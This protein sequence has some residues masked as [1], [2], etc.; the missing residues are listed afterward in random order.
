M[1]MRYGSQHA[2]QKVNLVAVRQLV[3]LLM[4]TIENVGERLGRRELETRSDSKDPIRNGY[5]FDL[6][7]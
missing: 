3:L 5:H 6:V 1:K 2:I 7:I 4:K